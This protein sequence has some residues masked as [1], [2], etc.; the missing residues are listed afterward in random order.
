ML[1]P[2][3]CDKIQA[4]LLNYYA[5]VSAFSELNQN[6]SAAN[7][8]PSDQFPSNLETSLLEGSSSITSHLDN[9]CPNET[10]HVERESYTGVERDLEELTR[11][12]MELELR[13]T[14]EQVKVKVLL[15]SCNTFLLYFP[16]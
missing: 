11:Q 5:G 14:I 4:I 10:S 16:W 15:L 2:V 9:A 13:L 3:F 1:V 8:A 7:F 12:C 6:E